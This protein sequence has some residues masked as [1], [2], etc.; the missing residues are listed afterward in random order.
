VVKLKIFSLNL[1]IIDF[2]DSFTHNIAYQFISSG[3]SCQIFNEISVE[4]DELESFD[5]I[6][7]SPGPGL[8]SEKELIP[9]VF[10]RFKGRKPIVGICLGIQ[11][12]TE[13]CGGQ[14]YNLESVRHGMIKRLLI[15]D[16][17]ND[18]ISDIKE[19]SKVGLYHS[20]ACSMENSSLKL[21]A[22]DDDGLPMI[23]ES[24]D[25]KLLGFQFH[26]ESIMTEDSSLWFQKIINWIKKSS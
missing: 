16:Q 19:N 6:L 14:I 11:A 17:T 18:V 20:W 15:Q 1:A 7:F 22:A 3:V 4:L 21:I 10:D 9:K 12:I 26:P 5:A 2:Q 13:S 8:P 24:K 23:V 25:D